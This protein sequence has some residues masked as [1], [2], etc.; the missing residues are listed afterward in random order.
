MKP[1]NLKL[2]AIALSCLLLCGSMTA[3]SS[4]SQTSSSKAPTTNQSQTQTQTQK[5]SQNSSNKTETSTTQ[6]QPSATEDSTTQGTNN[7]INVDAYN[8]KINYYM[9]LVETLQSEIVTIKEENYIEENDYKAR[10]KELESTVSQ[11][12][13]RIELIVS[14]GVITPVDPSQNESN[15]QPP[16]FDHISTK[17]V[18]EYVVENGKAVITKYVGNDVEVDIPSRIDNYTVYAIGESAFQ[19]SDVVSVT[20]PN[21]VRTIDWFAFAGCTSLQ[22]ITIPSSVT[23]VEYGAFDYCPKSMKV[24]CKKGSYIEAY[25]HSWGMNVNAE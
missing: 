5:P 25:A 16:S 8:E 17:N 15:T 14:G 23:L 19:N 3:C 12:L 1:L 10:I 21:T 22:S 9:A 4:K 20:I 11:L 18:F 7:D 13:D 24:N 2:T 6:K